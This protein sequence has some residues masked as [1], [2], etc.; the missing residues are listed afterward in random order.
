[1]NR[2]ADISDCGKFRYQL[3]RCWAPHRPQLGWI[4]LNPS[5]A[6]GL[7]DDPTI[8]KCMH[9]ARAWDYGGIL[10][11][12]LFH[13]RATDPRELTPPT[14]D[15]GDACQRYTEISAHALGPKDGEQV[16]KDVLDCPM[17][18]AAWGSHDVVGHTGR[19]TLIRTLAAERGKTLHCLAINQDRQPR[20]P[21]YVKNDTKPLIWYVPRQQEGAGQ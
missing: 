20:H 4:M 5:T 12:N 15:L 19:D 9:F 6:D 10:V 14:A 17:V 21:L 11:A 16:Y 8:R 2:A 18:M 13:L 7:A 3:V 1:M